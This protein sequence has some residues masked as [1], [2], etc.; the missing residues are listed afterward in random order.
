[1][2][3]VRIPQYVDE[4]AQIGPWEADEAIF[5]VL[6]LFGGILLK[7]MISGFI[8]GAIVAYIFGKYKSGKNRG[9]L[10]HVTYWYGLVPLP[11]IFCSSGYQRHWS[12]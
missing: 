1:M 4:M 5:L 7:A 11:G 2:D 12:H 9:M 8:V 10:M 3:R 6:G